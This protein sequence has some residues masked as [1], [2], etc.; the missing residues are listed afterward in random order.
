MPIMERV[1]GLHAH[2]KR[3]RGALGGDWATGAVEERQL[4]LLQALDASHCL[5]VDGGR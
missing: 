3:E 5:Q 2:G 4:V 1:A